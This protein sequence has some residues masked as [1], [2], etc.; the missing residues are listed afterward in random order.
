MGKLNIQN[1]PLYESLNRDVFA[2]ISNA[3]CA[4]RSTSKWLT[5]RY[6]LVSVEEFDFVYDK[7]ECIWD[8]NI[9]NSPC[10]V[11]DDE[12]ID[13]LVSDLDIILDR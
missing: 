13:R 5:E 4:N 3:I 8:S 7:K 6:F 2:E 9:F 11:Y 10:N 12:L 1:M